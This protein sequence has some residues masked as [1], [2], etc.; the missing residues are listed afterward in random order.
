MIRT[1]IGWRVE[2]NCNMVV[3]NRGLA[4][5][6]VRTSVRAAHFHCEVDVWI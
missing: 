3:M 4:K 2:N 6:R 5:E 1:I